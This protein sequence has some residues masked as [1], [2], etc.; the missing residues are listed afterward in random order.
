IPEFTAEFGADLS[1]AL[2]S[3]GLTQAFDDGAADFSGMGASENGN[4]FIK[5]VVHRTFIEVNEHGTKAGAA[6]VFLMPTN[7]AAINPCVTLDRPFLYMLV[8]LE[9]GIPF[10]IG[11]MA[12]PA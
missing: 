10:F 1:P 12:D 2:Q 4:L 11:T 5:Q 8:D 7:T 9:T 6:T 3:M